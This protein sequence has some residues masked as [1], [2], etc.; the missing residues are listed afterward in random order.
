M[1][2]ITMKTISIRFEENFLRHIEKM[3]KGHRYATLTEFIREAVRNR[4]KD[5]EREDALKRL[6]KFYGASKRK[7]TDAQLKIAREE[8]VKDLAKELG[9]KL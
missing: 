4:I 6:E 7:T 8:A 2:C 5:L 1:L 9:V 3:I